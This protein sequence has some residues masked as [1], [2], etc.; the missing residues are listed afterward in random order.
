MPRKKLITF[1]ILGTLTV[2]AAAIFWYAWY[3]LLH[4]PYALIFGGENIL[5]KAII[6]AVAATLFLSFLSLVNLLINDTRCR[7]ATFLLASFSIFSIFQF[8]PQTI[9]FALFFFLALCYFS[10]RSQIQIKEHLHF[11]AGHLFGP[12]L[13]SLITLISL[14]FAVQY[15]FAAQANISQFKLEI[16]A[17]IFDQV[18]DLIPSVKGIK[19]GEV[20]QSQIQIPEELI[21]YIEKGEFPPEIAAEIEKYLPAGV[22]IE[23]AITELQKIVHEQGGV[24]EV[25]EEDMRAVEE[26]VGPLPEEAKQFITAPTGGSQINLAG[27]IQQIVEAQLNKIIEPYKKYIPLVFAALAFLL[28]KWFGNFVNLLSTWLLAIFV[29]ILLWTK[30][31]KLETENVQAEKIVVK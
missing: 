11:S 20:L 4:S 18:V 21:P 24:I 8:D 5:S 16:P 9:A 28:I 7:I 15:F 26:Q 30:A 2:I 3:Q 25:S 22:T 17:H 31:A 27:P 1:S 29:K 13:G 14:I 19:T 6:F 12:T 10:I 23:Q